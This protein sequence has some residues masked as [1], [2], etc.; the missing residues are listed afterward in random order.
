MV[1]FNMPHLCGYRSV[2]TGGDSDPAELHRRFEEAVAGMSLDDLKRLAGEI[3]SF[4]ERVQTKPEQSPSLR[5]PRRSE[6]AIFRVRVDLEHA[7]PPIWRR[8]DVQ[9]DIGLDVF[10]QVLQSAFGWSDSHL[11]R[12]AVG[13]SPFDSNTEL[14]LCP[15]DV[16]EG[17]DDGTP[18][19]DVTLEETLSEPGDVLRYCYDYGDSWDLAIALESVL[20]PDEFPPVAVC[21]DG[22]RAAPPEDCGGLREAAD[23]AQILEDPTHFDVAEINRLLD[24]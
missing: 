17:E 22:R 5:K 16:E 6:P 10:H 4:S 9:S 21:V 12:F 8:L 19:K 20:P 11:H 3:L 24:R 15:Y 18:A 14:F 13:G 1:V 23:L 2:V 7:K